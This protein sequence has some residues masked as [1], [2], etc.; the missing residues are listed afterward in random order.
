MK[1][2]QTLIFLLIFMAISVTITS[3]AVIVIILNSHASS[4]FAQGLEAYDIAESGA[5]NALMRLLRDTSYTGETLTIGTGTATITLTGSNPYTITSQG[6]AGNFIRQVQ[7]IA[8][9]TSGVM[10]V[11]SWKEIF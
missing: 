1:R 10:G 4:K 3:A 11:T 8:T 2:G 5:E 9:F 7:V 6:T